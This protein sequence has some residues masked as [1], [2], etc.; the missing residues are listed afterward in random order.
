M[1]DIFD[2]ITRY[3]WLL[4]LIITAINS[5]A[6][7]RR[8]RIL[9]EQYPERTRGYR[10]FLIGFIVVNTLVWLVMGVGILF[11][12]VPSVFSY[13][14]PST[15]NPYVLAWHAVVIGTWILGV[16]WIFFRGGAQF[17]VDHPGLLNVNMSKPI[18][19]QLWFLACIGGGIL[20]EVMMWTRQV[21]IP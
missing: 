14:N 13:F 16:I 11:G 1:P 4:A 9:S 10:Q 7:Q 2:L 6:Y 20:G 19:V 12:G 5:V 17:V 18:Y 3:F 21:P 15:G 8:L